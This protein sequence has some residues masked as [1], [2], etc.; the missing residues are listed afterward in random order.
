ML[1][2]CAAGDRLPPPLGTAPISRADQEAAT[3]AYERGHFSAVAEH[4]DLAAFGQVYYDAVAW[5][6]EM[7]VELR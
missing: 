4:N 7:F 5:A 6:T 2:A 1:A 3:A